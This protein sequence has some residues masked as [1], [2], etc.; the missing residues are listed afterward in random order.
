MIHSYIDEY[1]LWIHL[2]KGVYFLIGKMEKAA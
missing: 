1:G 2:T